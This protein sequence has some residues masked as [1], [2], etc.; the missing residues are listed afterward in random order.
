MASFE[1]NLW[2]GVAFFKPYLYLILSALEVDGEVPKRDKSR[3][4]RI[5]QCY[6]VCLL[7]ILFDLVNQQMWTSSGWDIHDTVYSKELL[8]SNKSNGY[9]DVI[10]IIDLSSFR[11]IPWEN[12]VP[13]FLVSF[14][15]PTTKEPLSVDPRGVLKLTTDKAKTMGYDCF[16]GVEYEVNLIVSTSF[17][18][19]Y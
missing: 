11:R 18:L 2:C 4:F 12:N 7:S 9:R 10:A 13:F 19:L 15:D 16:A 6:L 14:L 5:L 3:W 1:A 8:I 17:L